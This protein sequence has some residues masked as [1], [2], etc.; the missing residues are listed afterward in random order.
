MSST[1]STQQPHRSSRV[2][3]C[4][5]GS[6]RYCKVFVSLRPCSHTLG[7][8]DGDK[9]SSSCR[10]DASP[11]RR[12]SWAYYTGIDRSARV[13]IG[14]NGVDIWLRSDMKTAMLHGVNRQT[15]P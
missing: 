14:S 8:P 6:W 13:L 3:V 2:L 4:S 5:G 10:N 11:T 12:G 15:G 9:C 7:S 1:A